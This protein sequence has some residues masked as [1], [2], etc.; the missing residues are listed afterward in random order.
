[1]RRQDSHEYLPLLLILLRVI[2][3]PPYLLHP[4]LSVSNR[5][6]K[7]VTQKIKTLIMLSSAG[8]CRV[9]LL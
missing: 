7:D 4:R 2:N 6:V 8:V 9:N 5:K 3:K 1:M